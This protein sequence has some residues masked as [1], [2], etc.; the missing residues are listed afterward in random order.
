MN[1]PI[2]AERSTA[3][4][5]A[6]LTRGVARIQAAKTLEE[7]LR[8]LAEVAVELVGAASATASDAGPAA[9]DEACV[10]FPLLTSSGQS[11]G[12]LWV[13]A[14]GT[15]FDTSERALLGELARLSVWAFGN[16]QLRQRLLE[17]DERLRLALEAASLGTWEHVPSSHATYWDERCK[18]I[19]GRAPDA[20]FEFDDY[21]AAL[22]P[23]DAERVFAGIGKAMD[24]TSGGE[25]SLQYRI[26]TTSGAERWVEAHGRC[27]FVDGVPQRING[28]LLDITTRRQAE[29]AILEAARRKD[30]FLALLG[31]ELRNP[32]APIVTALELMRLAHPKHAV[33]EREVIERQVRHMVRLVDDLLDLA[34]ISRGSI[35]LRREPMTLLGA[36]ERAIE[37]ASPLFEARRHRLELDVPGELWVDIDPVRFSQ[38]VSNLLT[39]A[40]KFTPV[41]GRV[42]VSA[43]ADAEAAAVALVIEDNGIGIEPRQLEAIFEPFVQGQRQLEQAQGGLGLGLALVR[44]LIQLHGGSVVAESMGLGAGSRFTLRVPLVAPRVTPRPS[45]VEP[46]AHALRRLKVLIVDDNEVSAEMLGLLLRELGYVVRVAYDGPRA[47]ALAAELEPDVAVLDIG[48]PVMDGYELAARLRDAHGAR[49]MRLVALTGYGQEQDLERSKRAGFE[50]HLV[51]PIDTNELEA[52]LAG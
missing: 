24:P 15:C 42:R 13:T 34:R 44:D 12:Q 22:H 11:F 32:L 6:R 1:E 26:R 37:I 17:Q 23:D 50:R 9:P 52:A 38:V 41:G 46:R 39:N 27:A 51:K 25:C 31:H 10:G 49:G 16:I 47:L 30:Q 4:S 28:T 29:E 45:V 8:L 7:G 21:M 5:L 3:A 36:V 43:R 14:R 20:P 18:I 48:L 33:R 35:T 19:F 40:A 2:D